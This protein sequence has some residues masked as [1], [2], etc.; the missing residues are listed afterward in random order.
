MRENIDDGRVLGFD[1]GD[2]FEEVES[3][4]RLSNGCLLSPSAST[5]SM[6][7]AQFTHASFTRRPL[8]STIQREFVDRGKDVRT[9]EN[10][11]R[12]RID[13]IHSI[14]TCA[15][16]PLQAERLHYLKGF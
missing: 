15:C 16:E 6:C 7:D 8:S 3:L 14:P 13:E 5:G 12:R 11:M 10:R 2:G 4:K 9:E 1:S